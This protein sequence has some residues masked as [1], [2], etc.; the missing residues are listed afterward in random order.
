MSGFAVSGVTL[1]QIRAFIAVA[2]IG[3]FTRAAD[4]IALSQPALTTCI[5][6]LE[7]Q[8]GVSLFERTT[9]RV[10]LT[11]YGME[12][13]PAAERVVR[14]LDNAMSSL[15]AI[16]TGRIGRVS[17][18]SIG[19]IASS[20]LP[21]ALASF[22]NKYP[23]VG[24][25]IGEDHSEGVR[26]K[27]FEGEAEFGLSGITEP[28]AEVEATP[29]FSDPIGVFCRADHPLAAVERPLRWADLSGREILNMG[30]E[31][32]IRSVAEYAPEVAIRLSST[33]YKVRNTHTLIALLQQ[34]GTIAALPRLSLPPARATIGYLDP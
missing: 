16:S 8:I 22:K 20:L 23:L 34:G 14:E 6:Q 15:K 25:D 18:A 31:T 2:K 29:F 10:E 26:R 13:L 21:H 28:F 1:R 33:A 27:V 12:F 19:S 24:V 30:H 4:A 17:M 32:Q 3:S 7:D 9:R 11:A 5:R